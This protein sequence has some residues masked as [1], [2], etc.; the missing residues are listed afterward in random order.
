[1]SHF[2]FLKENVNLV[3]ANKQQRT[4]QR[5]HTLL[6]HLTSKPSIPTN[7]NRARPRKNGNKQKQ[8]K[9]A[10]NLT[11]TVNTFSLLLWERRKGPEQLTSKLT[12]L[13]E[14]ANTNISQ[15]ELVFHT[16]I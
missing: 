11:F 6:G 9:A 13:T 15:G 1:M 16:N 10:K 2:Y 7:A 12:I 3:L 4:N 14:N 5:T 8:G